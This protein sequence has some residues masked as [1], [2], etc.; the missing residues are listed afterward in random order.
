MQLLEVG[1]GLPLL[2]E[3]RQRPVVLGGDDRFVIPVGAFD[4]AD[5]D[6]RAAAAGPVAQPHEVV[7]QDR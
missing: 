7:P 3:D 5:P 6:G 4:E 2:V 1:V